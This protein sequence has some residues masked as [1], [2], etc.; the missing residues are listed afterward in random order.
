M[1]FWVI[2]FDRHLCLFSKTPQSLLGRLHG[3]LFFGSG[4]IRDLGKN[5]REVL[6]TTWQDRHLSGTDEERTGM[7]RACP[8]KW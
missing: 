2:Y 5:S 7:S 3:A 4:F 8:A 1:H 6:L